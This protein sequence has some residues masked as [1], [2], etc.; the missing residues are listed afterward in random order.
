MDED[1]RLI[2]LTR[3]VTLLLITLACIL[4]AFA[5]GYM[6]RGMSEGSS[7]TFIDDYGRTIEM[8]GYPER[9]VSIAPTPTEVL[10]AV[11]AGNLVVGVDDYSN[12]PS[13]VLDLPKV[14][15]YE[16][17]LEAIIGLKPDL[18]ISSDLVPQAQLDAIEQQEIQ[19][20]I[21]ATRTMDDVF[22]DI[23]L[24][25]SI[26]DHAEEAETLVEQLRTRVDT[27]TA[28]TIAEDVVRPIVYLE[29]YPLWT[30][31]P[32]SFGHD[33]IELAGG[34]NIAENG[35]A[36][37]ITVSDE[38]VIAKDPEVIIY[39]VG[40]M[41]DTT[42]EDISSRQGWNVIDAVEN[43]RIYSIDDDLIS[44]YGPRIVDGLEELA[45]LLHPELFPG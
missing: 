5:G 40:V 38:F 9:I 27:V 37:Y 10:Y 35:S 18:I 2:P 6:I 19:Y 8:E 42:A 17:N 26:T 16:L 44:R 33:L 22:K 43:D 28:L 24:I 15:S 23:L 21:L 25:G 11:G 32:G 12:Y 7:L 41:T 3:L 31:G 34:R 14:G 13:E 36:E 30:F 4:A 20:I 1:S 45:R 29:Y 39:S